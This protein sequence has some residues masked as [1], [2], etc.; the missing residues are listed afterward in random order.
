MRDILTVTSD[1]AFVCL[2]PR[3][4]IMHSLRDEKKPEIGE[5]VITTVR[6]FGTVADI[7]PCVFN[8]AVDVYEKI[9]LLPLAFCVGSFSGGVCR[10]LNRA[11]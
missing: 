6:W 4:L 1:L 9:R 10:D 5:R 2:V 7:Q 8:G 11:A 3:S